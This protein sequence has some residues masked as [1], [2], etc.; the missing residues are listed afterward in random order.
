M[1]IAALKLAIRNSLLPDTLVQ[2]PEFNA[3]GLASRLKMRIQQLKAAY[4]TFHDAEFQ[5]Q[6]QRRF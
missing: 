1:Q 3:P 2:D 5:R 6:K 4:D